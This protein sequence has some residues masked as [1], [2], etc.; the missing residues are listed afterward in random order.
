MEGR[1]F[2]LNL[3]NG[4]APKLAVREAN[5]TPTGLEGDR[6]RDLRFHGGPERALC[7]FSLE[8]ILELQAD[9]H[10]IFPGSVGENVTVIGLDWARLEPGARLALGDEVLIEI[11]SFAS[12]CK[13][14]AG[15]FV[16]GDFKRISHKL[17]PGDSRLY[18][19]VLRTG[20]I[21]A[22]QRVKVLADSEAD[23]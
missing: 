17:R 21:A 5:L 4:G 3:S 19:R 13:V 9:G 22:G 16:E 6:Q 2:Q 10:P 11:S 14:I 12:P 8:R 1:I 20:R 15:S 18:A 23:T 7:L